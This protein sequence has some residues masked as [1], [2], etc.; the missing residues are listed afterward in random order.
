MKAVTQNRSRSTDSHADRGS[1]MKSK[2]VDCCCRTWVDS[3]PQV[4]D[5]NPFSEAQFT[6][7]YRPDFPERFGF[8]DAKAFCRG[9]YNHVHTIR[10]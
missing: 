1:S 2:A 9:W 10:A 3:R 6:L 7:K 5:D 8:Q 4:S